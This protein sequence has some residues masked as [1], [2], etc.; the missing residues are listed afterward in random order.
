[1]GFALSK[2]PHL[3]RGYLVGVP[4]SLDLSVD[5]TNVLGVFTN[6]SMTVPSS[7][8]SRVLI[9][10]SSLNY[11]RMILSSAEQWIKVGH[12]SPNIL[13]I[14]VWSFLSCIVSK[15]Y[16]LPNNDWPK[17]NALADKARI[18]HLNLQAFSLFQ[19]G[20]IQ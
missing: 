9:W 8:L 18:C 16:D 10:I 6:F 15:A 2:W 4:F 3:H 14:S 1:M 7:I 11:F 19:I 13:V 5:R 20:T 17:I 12:T